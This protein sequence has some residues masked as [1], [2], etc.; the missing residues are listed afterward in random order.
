MGVTQL[1]RRS[2]GLRN[3]CDS[4]VSSSISAI[5]QTYCKAVEPILHHSPRAAIASPPI[6]PPRRRRRDSCER[7][8]FIDKTFNQK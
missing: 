7:L 8:L 4:G 6:S 1:A 3:S 2:R 5:C